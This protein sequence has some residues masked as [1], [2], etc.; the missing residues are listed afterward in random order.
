MAIQL[1]KKELKKTTYWS[2][3]RLTVNNENG[4]ITE[5]HK[6]AQ[7]FTKMKTDWVLTT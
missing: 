6:D 1:I 7:R 5:R 2:K 3:K 4:I